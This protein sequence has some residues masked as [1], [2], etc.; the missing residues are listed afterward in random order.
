QFAGAAPQL[1]TGVGTAGTTFGIWN[2]ASLMTIDF[3][4]RYDQFEFSGRIPIYESD[5]YRCYGLLGPR[6]TWFWERFRWRT[7]DADVLGLAVGTDAAV[8]S[9]LVS[10]RLWGIHVGCGNEWYMGTTPVGAFSVSLDLQ[11]A[12]FVDFVSEAVK[13]ELGDFSIAASRHRKE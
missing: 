12:L 8:Y 2:A 4:Q 1:P 3:V 6:L 9:N 13:Y 11:F 5:C 10:N 7:V